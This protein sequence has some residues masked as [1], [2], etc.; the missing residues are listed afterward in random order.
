MA[1]AAWLREGLAGCDR[2]V[3]NDGCDLLRKDCAEHP[4]SILMTGIGI[5]LGEIESGAWRRRVVQQVYME[6]GGEPTCAFY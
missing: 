6:L 4:F 5:V 1:K 3:A 2:G